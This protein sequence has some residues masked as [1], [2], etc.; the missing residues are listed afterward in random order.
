MTIKEIAR[1][2]GVSRGTVD[3]VINRR[4]RVKPETEARILRAI[5]S[6]GYT[7]NIVG[8]AL[9]VKRTAPVIGAVLCSE[10]NPF[11]DD[12]LRGFDRARAELGD[13]GATLE[14]RAMRGHDVQRQLELIDAL[15][16]SLSALVLQ[17]LNDARVE[18]RIRSLKERGIPTVTVNSDIENSCRCCYVGSDYEA[19]G[20]TAAGLMRL[21]TGGRARLGVLEG[22]ETLMGHALR[23]RGFERRLSDCA[24]QVRIVAREAARDDPRR[25]YALTRRMLQTHADL[26]ALFVVAACVD[27]VCRAVIDAGRE[28]GMRVVA[29]DDVPATR[30]MMRRGLVRAVV[31]QQPVEQGYRAVREALEMI[32]S[33]EMPQDKRVIMENQ[34]K[35]TEN[36]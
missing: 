9:T 17:P 36:L 23:L 3:R 13:Y 2:C 10:G 32:L 27:E 35:I 33:G 29:Y 14:M 19:G 1:M 22:V 25:A 16:P 31:C 4:G 20:R 21:V 7:K 28:E 30:A 6:A 8:R 15:A 18:A 26:D 5:E 24:P 11:F 34:I 12:V